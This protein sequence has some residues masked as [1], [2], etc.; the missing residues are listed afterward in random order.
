MNFK[1]QD[2]SDCEKFA[3]SITELPA[4]MVLSLLSQIP[5]RLV[6]ILLSALFK[7][8][9]LSYTLILKGIAKEVSLITENTLS[10]LPNESF[11]VALSHHEAVTR[12]SN[13]N[14]NKD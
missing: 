13:N 1:Q 10:M 3:S 7:A 14:N 9:A 5:L 6:P 11:D 12:V 8:P 2:E 4:K